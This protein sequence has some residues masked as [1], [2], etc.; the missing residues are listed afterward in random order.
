MV[1]L[2]GMGH[3]ISVMILGVAAFF[4]KGQVS[5]LGSLQTVLSK[6]SSVTEIA[7]GLSLIVI[8]LLV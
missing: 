5:Q 2:W 8:G 7:V 6:A 1:R 3:G 4:V